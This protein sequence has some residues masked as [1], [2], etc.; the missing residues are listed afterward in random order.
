ME[1]SFTAAANPPS[2]AARGVFA[3]E[4]ASFEPEPTAPMSP[5]A[6]H[7]LRVLDLTRVLAGPWCTQLL[8][9]LGADVIKVER[10]G[11]GDDTRGWGP[12]FLKDAAGHDTHEAAYYLAANRG[13]RSIAIDMA[14]PE[15]QALVR[16]LAQQADVLVENYKVGQLARYGLDYAALSAANPRLVYCS[17]TGFGQTG[18]YKD[19]AGYDFI[20]QGLGGFM[21]VTGERDDLPGG[22]PQKA[23]VA[24]SDLMTGMYATVAILAAIEHRHTSG[25]GQAIDMALMDTMVAMLANLNTNYLTTGVAPRRAGNAHQ[26]I[27][28]YQVFAAADGHVIVAVGN[29]AQYAK[30]CEIAGRPDLAR[31]PRFVRNAGRVRHREVLVPLLEAVVRARPVRF[32]TDGLEAA[33]V[34]CGPI[35][36]IAQ[37]FAD[38][39]VQSRGMRIDLPHPSARQVP[40]VA[41]PIKMSATPPVFE[42]APPLLGQHTDEILRGELGLDAAR[43]AALRQS[44]V[45]A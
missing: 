6:L 14:H 45:V 1:S 7:G 37:A 24:V 44:G 11:S 17:I 36:S 5:A 29:D 9:D 3:T 27:V 30:F 42:R 33:G 35:N 16:R 13:K 2:H 25:R 19:R 18:P 12:P 20:I 23:G 15:G 10:P 31:D 22:G 26:N 8:A 4:C 32:W 41:S 28:P 34:P 43:I 21:S 39:Q 40:L 38:P